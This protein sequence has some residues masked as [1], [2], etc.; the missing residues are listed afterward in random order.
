M[1][2]VNYIPVV[3]LFEILDSDQIKTNTCHVFLYDKQYIKRSITQ[4]YLTG[5][6]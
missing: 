2:R 3:K 6:K 4:K 5:T 1:S